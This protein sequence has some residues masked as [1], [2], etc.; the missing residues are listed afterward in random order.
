MQGLDI[1]RGDTPLLAQLL[2]ALVCMSGVLYDGR[3]AR[4]KATV[5]MAVDK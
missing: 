1:S 2:S 5:V 4:R 3:K